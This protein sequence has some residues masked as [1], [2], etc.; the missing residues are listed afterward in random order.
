MSGESFNI[1]E[2]GSE[3]NI[4]R[5]LFLW[6]GVALTGLLLSQFAFTRG[7]RRQILERDGYRCVVCGATDHLEA[8]H[9]NH[10]KKNPRYNDPGN[11]RTLCTDCHYT[12]HINRHGNNGLTRSQNEW[13]INKI[14]D[15]LD[16]G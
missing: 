10:S 9:I 11:G 5:P 1:P 6:A 14:R 8:A 15:R 13:A 2:R 3:P 7:V 12:D 16:V 4:V